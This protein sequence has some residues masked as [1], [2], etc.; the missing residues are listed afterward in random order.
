MAELAQ[1]RRVPRHSR[2]LAGAAIAKMTGFAAGLSPAVK[3]QLR[4]FS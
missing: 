2:R 4:G 3:R 1:R